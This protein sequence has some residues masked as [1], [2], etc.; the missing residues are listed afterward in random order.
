[1]LSK[2]ALCFF[3]NRWQECSRPITDMYYA[4]LVLN[5]FVTD[6]L[7]Q[8]GVRCFVYSMLRL[9]VVCFVVYSTVNTDKVKECNHI[10]YIK[11]L[12][13]NNCRSKII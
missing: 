10:I 7:F 8:E 6:M 5:I 2:L 1:V 13:S 4:N 11:I 9:R 3:H 12:C